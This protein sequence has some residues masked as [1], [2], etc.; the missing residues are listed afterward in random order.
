MTRG[1]AQRSSLEPDHARER[2]TVPTPHPVTEFGPLQVHPLAV[3][4]TIPVGHRKAARSPTAAG[5]NTGH[6]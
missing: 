3:A 4:D 5:G 1:L 6:R 2:V